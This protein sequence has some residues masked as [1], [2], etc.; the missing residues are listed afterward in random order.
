MEIYILCGADSISGGPELAHQFCQA[1]NELTGIKAK[2]CYM[3]L[4]APLNECLPIDTQ[5]PENYAI[6]KTEHA[7]TLQE[8]DS[9]ENIIIVPEGLTYGIYLFLHAKLVIWWMSVDNY[10]KST[11]ESNLETLKKRCNLHLVQSYYAK[12]YVETHFSGEV[13]WLTDYINLKHGR[14]DIFSAERADIALFNPAKGLE[15]MLPV[16]EKNSWLHWVAIHKMSIDETIYIMQRAKVYIDLGNHPGK[17]RMPREAAINGC[18]VI[19]NKEG[20]A[21]FQL[22]VPIPEE[23]K[24]EH[25][26][27][28]YDEIEELLRDIC[29]NFKVHQKKFED[30]RNWIKGEKERFDN[31]VCE[32]VS[33]L[34]LLS[35]GNGI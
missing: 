22:D 6:Y 7:R 23:Y 17:D 28:R 15:N 5:A 29:T 20:S 26:T 27:K 10:I 19:T 3:R 9:D 24:F 33:R 34:E 32:V 12:K 1:V 2:M 11:G 25:V 16:I 21:A 4:N 13:M 30:Y 8:I 18:C 35:R 31:E 14:G